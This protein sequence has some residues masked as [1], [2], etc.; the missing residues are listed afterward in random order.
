LPL[1]KKL[2]KEHPLAATLALRSMVEFSLA[3]AR[4]DRSGHPAYL[5][6]IHSD[7]GR[8]SAFWKRMQE[9]GL[10]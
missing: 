5:A 8:K 3:E 9:L 6:A 2:S 10:P 1:P 7:H 4:F